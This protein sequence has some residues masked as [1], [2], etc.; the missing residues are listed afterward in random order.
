[1]LVKI[2]IGEKIITLFETKLVDKIKSK[3]FNLVK[4][5]FFEIS[6]EDTVIITL[7]YDFL[8]NNQNIG[9][10]QINKDKNII[11]VNIILNSKSDRNLGEYIEILS[12][13]IS[14]I[15]F[16]NHT[17]NHFNL[18]YENLEYFFPSLNFQKHKEEELK[19]RKKLN[20]GYWAN[21]YTLEDI[22]K[23]KIKKENRLSKKILSV[24]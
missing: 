4:N 20:V 21:N 1:M 3:I 14:H 13:E 5:S 9:L 11:N 2:R 24:L 22:R 7:K 12:H 18:K 10:I 17:H 19:L 6:K 16:Q 15:K 8:Q 23:K